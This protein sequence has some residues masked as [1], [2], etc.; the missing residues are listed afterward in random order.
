MAEP[1]AERRVLPLARDRGVAVI[2]NRPFGGG[3]LAKSLRSTPV[4]P[5][6]GEWGCKTWPQLLLKFVVSHP[7]VT[8]AIPGSGDADHVRANLAGGM[9][10]MPDEGTRAR[11]AAAARAA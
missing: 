9:G 11:I 3:G 10:P 2:A 4:P 6:A 5:W 8:C 7:A 1:E